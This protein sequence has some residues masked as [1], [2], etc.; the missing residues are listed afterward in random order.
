MKLYLAGPVGYGTPGIEW[1]EEI[2]NVLRKKGHV[3][4]DPIENDEHYPRVVELNEWKKS[5]RKHWIDIHNLMQDIFVDDN[6]FIT[7][8]DYIICYFAG[9]ALGTSSEQGISYYL[10]T[11]LKKKITIISIF[12][13]SFNPDEWTLC[14]S[15][16]VFF[17]MKDCLKF[18]EEL[19]T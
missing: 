2:K 15:D 8:C 3:V 12:D 1:K 14:C 6:N 17:S 9:R 4:Y 18:L 16:K 10:K 11:F 13:K 19:R 5:P 7:E